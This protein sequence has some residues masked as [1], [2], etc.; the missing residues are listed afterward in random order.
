MP[1]MACIKSM[2]RL[3]FI[4][5][6]FLSHSFPQLIIYDGPIGKADIEFDG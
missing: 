4:L 1:S 5:F 2:V 3:C 6:R